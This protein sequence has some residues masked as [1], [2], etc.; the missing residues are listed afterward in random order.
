MIIKKI[1]I[2][3]FGKLTDVDF[4]LSTSFNLIFGLN[5]A[6]KSTLHQLL[7]G[8]LY[9]LDKNE[10]DRWKPWF[11][12]KFG[13]AV[14]Y[15]LSN[16][17]EFRIERSFSPKVKTAVFDRFGNEITKDFPIDRILD[18]LVGIKHL[19]IGRGVFMNSCFIR[20]NQ[21]GLSE[22]VEEMKST[23]QALRDT[24]TE[25]A[26]ARKAKQLLEDF[27][28]NVVGKTERGKKTNLGRVS[29]QIRQLEEEREKVVRIMNDIS[30][31]E[32]YRKDL[33]KQNTDEKR[34]LEKLNYILNKSKYLKLC[35]DLETI[36]NIDKELSLKKEEL[37]KLDHYKDFPIEKSGELKSILG[38]IKVLEEDKNS[39]E[40]ERRKLGEILGQKKKFLSNLD[41]FSKLSDRDFTGVDRYMA[42]IQEHEKKIT[43]EKIDLKKLSGEEQKIKEELQEYKKR[44]GL[45]DEHIIAELHK[46]SGSI[47]GS[48]NKKDM[49]RNEEEEISNEINRTRTRRYISIFSIFIS[50]SVMVTGVLLKKIVIVGLGGITAIGTLIYL[51]NN[52]SRHKKLLGQKAQKDE[53]VAEL[54]TEIEES[55]ASMNNILKQAKVQNVEDFI[56]E[57][58]KYQS[59]KSRAEQIFVSQTETIIE[60]LGKEVSEY[61]A[62]IKEIFGKVEIVKDEE[63]ITQSKI[64]NIRKNYINYT[65]ISKEFNSLQD[66]LNKVTEQLISKEKE[67]TNLN[68]IV[69]DIFTKSKVA[70]IDEFN[71]GLK[72]HQEWNKKR[73]EIEKLEARIAGIEGAQNIETLNKQISSLRTSL[74]DAEK[75]TPDLK[76][77]Q[78][79]TNNISESDKEMKRTIDQIRQLESR[80]KELEGGIKELCK[81][82]RSLDDLD[83][84]LDER[85]KRYKEVEFCRDAVLKA[86]DTIDKAERDFHAQ[87]FAPEVDS[88]ALAILPQIGIDYTDIKIDPSFNIKV[89]V[90]G[91]GYKDIEEFSTG[92]I[93]QVYLTIRMAL[94]HV[95]TQG[96]EKLPLFLDET[97]SNCD[98]ERWMQ[99][100]NFILD[101]SNETQVLYFTCHNH[102]LE[103]V[104][105]TLHNRKKDFTQ[106]ETGEFIHVAVD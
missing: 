55:E 40:E 101:I 88:T 84:E 3:G 89:L 17:E 23:L 37:A 106:K 11:G 95:L 58:Q 47:T 35:K 31:K 73:E 36:V 39:L 98:R 66:S 103:R 76:A 44:F 78:V 62:K 38:Q 49:A 67:I 99:I 81:S 7:L 28:T 59:L 56:N 21:I 85:N 96:G 79:S 16:G 45:F 42:L 51:L 18:R 26:S 77:L 68:K 1:E 57:Y 13:G 61:K 52:W 50:M 20:Q 90:R 25:K 8:L 32:T 14:I 4:N 91:L 87:Y 93:D 43:Q 29:A 100:M 105:E 41:K 15:Q 60:G 104:G 22:N 9:G 86:L 2:R 24:S 46:L 70:D 94:C 64:D 33:N 97:F 92:T 80:I 19:G 82:S 69:K 48:E 6:G 71:K 27:L 75:T 102:Q 72:L 5:E 65:N 54:T 30:E 53:L 10:R 12:E 63:E 74:G 34:K 83:R